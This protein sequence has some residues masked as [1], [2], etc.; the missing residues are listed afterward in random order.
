LFEEGYQFDFFQAVRVLEHLYPHR[1]PACVDASPG[2]EVVRFRT[3]VSLGYPP[4]AVRGIRAG[5]NG[6]PVE[7]AV[8]FMGLVGRLGVLP[9][10]YT[11]LILERGRQ[12]D[13]SLREF[14][15]L[16]NH[17]LITLFYRAWEK[18]HFPVGYERAKRKGQGYDR[19]SRCLLALV[20]MGTGGL[21]ERLDVPDRALMFYG[22]LLARH[23]RSASALQGLLR[24]YFGVPVS[25]DQMTGKW[26]PLPRDK[27]TRLGPGD[28]NNV[29]GDTAICGSRVWDPHAKFT[30]RV[31]PVGIGAFYQFLPSGD[32]FPRLCQL[33]GLFAGKE[34][35]FDVRQTLR[36][37][38]VPAC[39]LG[40]TRGP[41]PLLGWS[42]WLKV[43]DFEQD[44]SDAVFAG[45]LEGAAA[46]ASANGGH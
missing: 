8:A 22:G 18:H 29:L 20:G 7:L 24:D 12:K 11:E 35:D 2:A 5:E 36:A 3:D 16:F 33:T 28:A 9:R 38:E 42:T 45:R 30:V 41:A 32:A 44:A 23:C 19:F 21:L 27:R 40:D 43:R 34:F 26:L 6:G 39:R 1:E 17:R 13:A 14:L 10:H 25:I 37:A 15:D 31:G 46:G 4:S